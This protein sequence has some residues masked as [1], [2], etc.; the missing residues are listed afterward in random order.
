[1][2]ANFLHF[3][4]NF[5]RTLGFYTYCLTLIFVVNMI[6]VNVIIDNRH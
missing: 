4:I 5:A 3:I 6:T 1:M 2:A